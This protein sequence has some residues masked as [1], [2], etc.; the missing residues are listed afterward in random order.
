MLVIASG[1]FI[2]VSAKIARSSNPIMIHL[3]LFFIDFPP[4]NGLIKHE[5]YTPPK[6]DPGSCNNTGLAITLC[7]QVE[8]L[9]LILPIFHESFLLSQG[10]S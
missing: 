4:Y 7:L 8:S 1:V 6:K 3:I 10:F 5:E 9:S 2:K